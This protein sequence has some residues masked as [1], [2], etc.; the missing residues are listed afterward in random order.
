MHFPASAACVPSDPKYNVYGGAAC[1]SFSDNRDETRRACSVSCTNY[2]G[3]GNRSVVMQRVGFTF[4]SRLQNGRYTYSRRPSYIIIYVGSTIDICT[5][6]LISYLA[7]NVPF[8]HK[9]GYIGD[10]TVGL[11]SDAV[12]R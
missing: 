10:N 4:I 11:I 2:E 12:I 3:C 1:R 7:F 6:G 8:Q 9:Y 5:V